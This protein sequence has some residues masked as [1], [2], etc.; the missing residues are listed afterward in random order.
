MVRELMFKTLVVATV[1]LG[2]HLRAQDVA[3]P[4]DEA[5][6]LA[7]DDSD[8]LRKAKIP[9]AERGAIARAIDTTGWNGAVVHGPYSEHFDVLDTPIEFRDLNHDGIS[10][11]VVKGLACSPTGNC[12]I[13][14]L[15]KTPSGYRMILNSLGQSVSIQNERFNGFNEIV[16]YMHG[17]A[18]SGITKVYRYMRGRY[19]RVGCFYVEFQVVE[20]G[21]VKELDEPRVT[22]CG[23]PPQ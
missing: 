15:K 23:A 12:A 3:Y 1:L 9:E 13:G 2:L 20:G 8:V 14:V 5:V 4:K 6:P 10:E 11:V 17:S 16:V 18:T 7:M 21:E 22:P 19:R